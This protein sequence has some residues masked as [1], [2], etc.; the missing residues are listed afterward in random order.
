[1]IQFS[2]LKLNSKRI[3]HYSQGGEDGLLEYILSKLPHRDKFLVEFGAWDGKHL[4]NGF[5]LINQFGYSGVLIEMDPERFEDLEKNMSE[6][7]CVCINAMVGYEGNSKLDFILGQTD[8]P[9]DF[10]LLSIDIDG[11]DYQVWQSVDKYKPKVVIIEINSSIFPGV[12]LINDPDHPFELFVSGSSVSA[13]NKLGITKGYRLIANVGCNAIFVRENLYDLF[14]QK[15]LNEFDLF[16]FE[17]IP[18]RELNYSQRIRS[19]M[20]AFARPD[21][22]RRLARRLAH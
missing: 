13:I 18:K 8:I 12:D 1:M 14:H 6:Y 3:T 7:K 10:D 9:Q 19:F 21:L 22:I 16:T 11:N 2:V 15:I 17:A 20:F 4:S 5:H